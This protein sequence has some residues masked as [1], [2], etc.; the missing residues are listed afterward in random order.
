MYKIVAA[1]IGGTN[2]RLGLFELDDAGLR[3]N[4]SI[5][6]STQDV[7]HTDAFVE[8][9]EAALEISLDMSD[10]LVA[11]IAGPVE[12]DSKGHL[13]NGNLV[14]DFTE[15]QRNQARAALI[16]DFIAQAYAVVS[17]EGERAKLL[18]GPA[19]GD[20]AAVRAVIGAGTGLGQAMLVR[21]KP[22]HQP[23]RWRPIP[24]ENGWSGFPF[25][26]P[27]EDKFHAF[28][29]KE[30]DIPFATG[31][32][33]VTGRGLAALHHFLTGQKLTPPEVGKLALGSETETLVWY[34]RFY[35]RVVRD[36]MLSTMSGGGMWIAGGIAAQNPLCVQGK[37]F[38]EE[39]YG[40]PR[41]EEYLRS[42]PLYLIEDKN[43]GLWGAARLGQDML[44]AGKEI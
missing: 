26:G 9:V 6:I 42:I 41:W 13:S 34:S 14:L 22:L 18:S 27:D 38:M 19:K 10:A 25:I 33:V 15:R 23:P 7:T 35:A 17:P 1:D 8:A 12:G 2:C 30:L 5:W 16:N 4:R 32:D 11:S 21:E 37:W 3:L 24:S 28:I 43:S 39:L 31:D 40:F 36:W 44:F 20:P 29:C